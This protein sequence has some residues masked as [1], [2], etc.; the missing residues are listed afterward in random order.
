LTVIIIIYF[1]YNS[2]YDWTHYH[3]GHIENIPLP[4]CS[5]RALIPRFRLCLSADVS[6]TEVHVNNQSTT[7][8]VSNYLAEVATISDRVTV[9]AEVVT[10]AGV[11][12]DCN[13]I[14][15]RSR[16]FA[17]FLLIIIIAVYLSNRPRVSRLISVFIMHDLLLDT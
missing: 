6:G 5:R 17:I 16:L 4:R 14:Y 7:I 10:W 15:P 3:G 11:W 9:S 13:I 1:V 8:Q 12:A 2:Y